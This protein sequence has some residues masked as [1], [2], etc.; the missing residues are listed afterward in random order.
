MTTHTANPL[1]TLS[2]PARE[3][4]LFC[5]TNAEP[6][7]RR[8]LREFAEAEI[9]IPEGPYQGLPYRVSRQPFAG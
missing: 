8:T 5:L 2:T 7:K 9:Y 6:R 4:W 3:E 1:A